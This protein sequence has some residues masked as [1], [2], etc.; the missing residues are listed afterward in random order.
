MRGPAS[1][2][3]AP[4]LTRVEAEVSRLLL[5]GHGVERGLAW[6]PWWWPRRPHGGDT[7]LAVSWVDEF[8]LE[9]LGR[10]G[11]QRLGHLPVVGRPAVPGQ[12]AAGAGRLGQ[13]LVAA[14]A[15]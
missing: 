5:D 12:A 10:H 11:Y 3:L 14:L 13:E 6:G 4:L 9:A 1:S 8:L 2:A 7:L 15:L